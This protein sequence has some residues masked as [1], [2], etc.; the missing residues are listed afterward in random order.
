[1]KE[2]MLFNLDVFIGNWESVNLHPTV[3]IYK[4]DK[5]YLLSIIHINETTQQAQPATYEILADEIGYYI[6]YDLKRVNVT[7]D[8]K[9]DLLTLSSLGDYMRN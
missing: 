9:T 5:G 2:E 7:Y 4:N 3:M 1:M 6:F 8:R